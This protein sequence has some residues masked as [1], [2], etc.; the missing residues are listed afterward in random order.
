[1]VIERRRQR[2]KPAEEGHDNRAGTGDATER[3]GVV[4]GVMHG[5]SNGMDMFVSR[6]PQDDCYEYAARPRSRQAVSFDS[7]FASAHQTLRARII[8]VSQSPNQMYANEYEHCVVRSVRMILRLIPLTSAPARR[9]VYQIFPG[10]K[11]SREDPRDL[12]WKLIVF[13]PSV[14]SS[15]V[16]IFKH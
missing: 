16:P 6:I 14:S 8:I 10:W 15:S 5:F 1:M 12:M 11:R 9:M 2:A 13:N 4:P 3:K 7:L